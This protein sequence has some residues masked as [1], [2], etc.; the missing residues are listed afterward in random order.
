MN[1]ISVVLCAAAALAASLAG[2]IKNDI[3]YPRIQ[4]NFLSME[5]PELVQPAK[6]DSANRLVTLTFDEQADIEAVRLSSY[7][8]TP[9]SRVVAGDLS[10]PLNLSQPYIVTLQLYQDY[11]WTIQGLQPIERYFTVEGQMGPTDIDTDACRVRVKISSGVGL[12]EVPV[13]SCKLGPTG[14]TEVPS[15]AGKR[16]NLSQPVE[17]V[18]TAHGRSTTWT[19]TAEEVKGSVETLRADPGSQ[20]AWVYGA[21]VEGADRGVEYRQAGMQQW[22]KAP[23]EWVTSTGST[24]YALLRHL[25]PETDYEARAYSDTERGARVTFTTG[26]LYQMPNSSLSEWWKDGKVWNPWPE[27]GTPYWD[28]GNKGAT[29]LGQ[30]NSVPTDDTSSGTGTAAMLQSK[31]VSLFGI[32]KLAAGNIFTG[33][34]VRTDG[35]NG[36]L[37]FGRPC[38]LRPTK[39]RGYFKYNCVDISRTNSELAY[40]MGRPDTCNIYIAMIDCDEPY[41]IRTNPKNRQL[42]DPQGDYVVAYGHEQHGESIPDWIPFEI[43]LDYYSTE[44]T[45]KYIVVVASASKYG[46]FFTG[47]DGSTLWLDDLELV[48]DY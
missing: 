29:T 31:F 8:I 21:A 6:I 47:G 3:P 22:V 38:S 17:V 10:A 27:G 12:G 33:V 19:I 45:P 48:Y 2:C 30:S 43:P 20:V 13:L 42:F 24:F 1:R 15:L 39:L 46:D 25:Q 11:D 9:G 34:Y 28:T 7:T 16:V 35:T 37:T 40:M 44:R 23:A 26:P 5:A 36:I 32:G 41:E 14:S 4:P 18:V